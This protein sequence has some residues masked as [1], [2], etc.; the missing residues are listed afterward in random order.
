MQGLPKSLLSL[1]AWAMSWAL[2]VFAPKERRRFYQ[3]IDKIFG[4]PRHS[5]FA[6]SFFKECARHQ[7]SCQLES[8]RASFNRSDITVSGQSELAKLVESQFDAQRGLIVITAHLGSWELAGHFVATSLPSAFHVLAKPSQFRVGTHLLER[9]RHRLGLRVLWTDKKSLLRDMT[10]TLRSGQSLGF[11]MDQKPKGRRGHSVAFFGHETEFVSGPAILAAKFHVP[12][13][14]CFC[15]REQPW[16][17]RLVSSLVYSPDASTPQP[18]EEK[19]TARMAATIEAII[20]IY[21]E[22]WTWNY[23]RWSEVA[24]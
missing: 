2:H 19:L 16:H 13:I 9:L 24:R 7:T 8:F 5:S 20:K 12:I 15:L 3:N 14:A 4:L 11:V 6:R 1:G 21:P 17:F 10:Q 23:K 18:T 22:Q